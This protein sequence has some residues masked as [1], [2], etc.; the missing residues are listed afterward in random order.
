MF[1]DRSMSR[2]Q[3]VIHGV[4]RDKDGY[5]MTK[6]D[7][8]G[9]N[10]W[11]WSWGS[12]RFAVKLLVKKKTNKMGENA[13]LVLLLLAGYKALNEK[14]FLSLV[15][16]FYLNRKRSLSPTAILWLVVELISVMSS[17]HRVFWFYPVC[18]SRHRLDLL[19]C[20]FTALGFAVVS[21]S[22]KI[23]LL[24]RWNCG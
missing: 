18:I 5:V 8:H 6:T 2:A 21:E 14:V 24:P 4:P 12:I 1:A 11:R 10:A 19:L 22:V 3:C 16:T 9:I 17:N 7:R 15:I 20:R 23:H 13:P